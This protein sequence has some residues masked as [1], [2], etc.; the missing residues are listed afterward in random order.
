MIMTSQDSRWL[1]SEPSPRWSSAV[2]EEIARRNPNSA[3]DWA[4]GHRR[5]RGRPM[6]LAPA[7]AE[8]YDDPHPFIVI[9]KGS[10]VGV[11][12]Y[13]ITQ[14]LWVADTGQGDRGN[15]MYL[16]P[17]EANMRDFASARI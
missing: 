8:I 3:L 9:Q 16:M 13:M 17:T 5:I 7:L 10:Q 6:E 14:V 2:F 15:A 12:E 1:N 11:S 4:R